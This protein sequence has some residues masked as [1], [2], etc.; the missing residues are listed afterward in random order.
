MAPDGLIGGFEH[1]RPYR[2]A[3]AGSGSDIPGRRMTEDRAVK[4]L[5]IALF[6]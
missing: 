5:T 6:F 1:G 4:L 3:G 2:I